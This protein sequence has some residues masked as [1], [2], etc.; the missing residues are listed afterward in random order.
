M[1]DVRV[2]SPTRQVLVSF[3]GM[4]LQ[5]GSVV[6]HVGLVEPELLTS[7]APRTT[8]HLLEN[9]C[10]RQPAPLLTSPP[11]ASV[12]TFRHQQ[13]D[14]CLRLRPVAKLRAPLLIR[15]SMMLTRDKSGYPLDQCRWG[16]MHG[17]CTNAL[18]LCA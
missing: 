6:A 12:R 17:R 7:V 8:L 1:Y 5:C 11:S 18:S 15:Y 10:T 14:H 2:W 3:D 9:T 4:A 16:Q 13:P